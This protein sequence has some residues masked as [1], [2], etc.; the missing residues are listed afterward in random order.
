VRG[1]PRPRAA[2]DLKK[3]IKEVKEQFLGPQDI[4]GFTDSPDAVMTRVGEVYGSLASSWDA[5]TEAQKTAWT[6]AEPILQRGLDAVNRLLTTEVAAFR[7]RAGSVLLE[8]FPP[9]DPLT[10]D[11][12]KRP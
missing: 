5:P 6:A 8:V 11:W 3:R 12:T 2:E 1:L 9:T 10:P 4:Q 7:Q